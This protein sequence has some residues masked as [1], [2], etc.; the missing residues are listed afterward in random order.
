MLHKVVDTVQIRGL[1]NLG[2]YGHLNPAE[3]TID[4]NKIIE[5]L[6]S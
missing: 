1:E 5:M 3:I 6:S 2:G 4:S